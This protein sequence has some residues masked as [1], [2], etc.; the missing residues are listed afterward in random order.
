MRLRLPGGTFQSKDQSYESTQ[1][2]IGCLPISLSWCGT[3]HCRVPLFRSPYPLRR[4][5]TALRFPLDHQSARC[6]PLES[7]E[8]HT[9]LQALLLLY[10]SRPPLRMTI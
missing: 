9:Y 3:Q 7:Q 2:E 8:M 5:L 1:T 4:D 6:S 10:T